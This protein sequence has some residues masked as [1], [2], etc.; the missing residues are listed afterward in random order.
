MSYGV[1]VQQNNGEWRAAS[2]GR[3]L[4]YAE[5]A[6]AH[7][8]QHGE[9]CRIVDSEGTVHKSTPEKQVAQVHKQRIELS[10]TRFIVTAWPDHKWPVEIVWWIEQLTKGIELRSDFRESV[11]VRDRTCA[12]NS[13]IKQAAIG[14]DRH[15]QWFV[16]L[17]SDVRPGPRTSQFLELETDVKACQVPMRAEAAWCMPNSFHES[18]WCTSRHVLENIQAPW[19]MQRYSADGTRLDGCICNY[20]RDKA[21]DAGFSISHGGWAEHDKEGSWCG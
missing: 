5:A 17:D 2:Q 12:R 21:L 16:F 8:E 7:Y 13:A 20:F 4:E 14:S 15:Y 10:R 1:E 9:A 6:Y 18:I 11:K 3:P 19:F